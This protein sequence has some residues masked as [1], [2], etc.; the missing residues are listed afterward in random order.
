MFVTVSNNIRKWQSRKWFALKHNKTWNTKKKHKTH[1][2]LSHIKLF[3]PKHKK[4]H[5]LQKKAVFQ[6]W[7][8][9]WEYSMQKQHMQISWQAGSSFFNAF[10]DFFYFPPM[11]D[12]KNSWWAD[13]E[14]DFHPPGNLKSAA[15]I[16]HKGLKLDNVR[17]LMKS[18]YS[19]IMRD[20]MEIIIFLSNKGI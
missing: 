15:K 3:H 20:K 4:A 19:R 7:R 17:W 12:C 5:I 2:H 9:V 16:L 8:V 6:H 10:K 14:C 1:Q 11:Q 13:G 18:F